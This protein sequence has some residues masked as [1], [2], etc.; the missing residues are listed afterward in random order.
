MTQA[1]E[2]ILH[3]FKANAMHLYSVRKAIQAGPAFV[4]KHQKSLIDSIDAVIKRHDEVVGLIELA[5]K[6]NP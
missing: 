6:V 3:A 2:D 5:T 1:R 4:K